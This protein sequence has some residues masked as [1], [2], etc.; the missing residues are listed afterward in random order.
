MSL[1]SGSRYNFKHNDGI[2]TVRKSSDPNEPGEPNK[3]VWFQAT[4]IDVF[5]NGHTKTL[6]VTDVIR[7]NNSKPV[8]GMTTMPY[9]WIEMAEEIPINMQ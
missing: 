3:N 8:P 1:K 5:D 4:V 2:Y 7:D 6:R 9:E